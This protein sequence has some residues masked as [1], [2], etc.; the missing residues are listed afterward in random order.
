MITS[1]DRI[2]FVKEYYFSRKLQEIAKIQNPIV[3]NLGIGNPDLPPSETT[4]SELIEASVDRE[5]HGYQ[6]YKGIPEL[7]KTFSE[8]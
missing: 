8:W 5:N 1:S 2:R 6:V 4:I 7:R 3:I